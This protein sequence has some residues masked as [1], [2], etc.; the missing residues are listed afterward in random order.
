MV[1]ITD[2]H[3]EQFPVE[4]VWAWLAGV[5]DPAIPYVSVIDL[6]IVRDVYWKADQLHIVT[7]PT[8]NG[9]PAKAQIDEAIRG[10]LNDH[11]VAHI[12]IE[13]RLAPAWTTDWISETG[14]QKLA[15]AGIAPPLPIEAGWQRL[16]LL[17]QKPACP[18]CGLRATRMTSAFGS[19]PC[20][21]MH[22]CNRC[23]KPFEYFKAI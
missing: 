22:T 8:W 7:T 15:A 11:G 6:G 2:K 17:R 14:K 4:R 1:S 16:P 12:T 23:Q 19:T 13:S 5:P 10:V 21:S 9:C 18:H 20:K 3:F